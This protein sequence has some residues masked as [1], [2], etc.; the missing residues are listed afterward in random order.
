MTAP[1]SQDKLAMELTR[2]YIVGDE[3]VNYVLE[4]RDYVV[5]SN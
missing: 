5:N 2:R 1:I 4:I 3:S